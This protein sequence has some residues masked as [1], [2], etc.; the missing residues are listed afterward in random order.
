METFVDLEELLRSTWS[1]MVEGAVADRVDRP[2]N[3]GHVVRGIL[4]DASQAATDFLFEEIAD[5]LAHETG[6]DIDYARTE[7]AYRAIDDVMALLTHRW[8]TGGSLSRV[9]EDEAAAA[10]QALRRLEMK[11]A[12][13]AGCDVSQQ[14]YEPLY[15]NGR[16]LVDVSGL[17]RYLGTFCPEPTDGDDEYERII[18]VLGFTRSRSQ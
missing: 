8:R 17:C 5:A 1:P 6:V 12:E 7:T 16:L 15:L 14:P 4:P 11:A 13:W 3:R 2:G 10:T 9:G 18:Q